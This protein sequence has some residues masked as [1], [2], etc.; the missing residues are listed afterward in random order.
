[1]RMIKVKSH[2]QFAGTFFSWLREYL[3]A[4]RRGRRAP[5]IDSEGLS[6]FLETRASH[7]A[8]ISLYGYLRTR[9]G[10]RYPELFQDDDFIASV[11]IAKWQ[12]MLACLSDIA[13]YAGG[14]LAQRWD[15][16]SAQ[17]GDV[18]E[19]AVESILASLGT[20]SDAGDSYAA[21]VARV[22]AR[23]KRTD[24]RTITDDE[25]PFCD[26]PAALVE[27]APIVEE[28]MQLDAE[29]VENSVRFRWQEVRRELRRDLDGDAL[30]ATAN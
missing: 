4:A 2:L 20:P 7:V 21:G 8:Q 11:N 18:M 1:M 25:G 22:R 28:L 9:A 27:W 23:L 17:V 15:A 14:L 29:I 16:P 30:L 19:A 12:M 6:R 5:I 13:V 3:G 10:T 24:W 26:S